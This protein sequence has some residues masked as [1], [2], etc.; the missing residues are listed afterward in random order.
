DFV[1]NLRQKL[2]RLGPHLTIAS[3]YYFEN[4]G[5]Q[6]REIEN[7]AQ[8]HYAYHICHI[9]GK[10]VD[11]KVQDVGGNFRL[12]LSNIIDCE[13]EGLFEEG[14][15]YADH[16]HAAFAE[17]KTKYL[18]LFRENSQFAYEGD[19][20]RPECQGIL[21]IIDECLTYIQE[22]QQALRNLDHPR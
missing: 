6:E 10:V 12:I 17:V 13:K 20:L 11:G 21:S 22:Q 2:L 8:F 15:A 7:L 16:A 5:K 3:S 4:F 14:E 9:G 1:L 18:N 19:I